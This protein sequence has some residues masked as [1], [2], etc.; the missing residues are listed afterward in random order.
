MLTPVGRAGAEPIWDAKALLKR[1]CS[2]APLPPAR[3]RGEVSRALSFRHPAIQYL[4]FI[5]GDGEIGLLCL[6]AAVTMHKTH[7]DRPGNGGLGP[8]HHPREPLGAPSLVCELC[9]AASR[10]VSSWRPGEVLHSASRVIH[11]LSRRRA[12]RQ[13]FWTTLAKWPEFHGQIVF[14]RR[15]LLSAP[16]RLIEYK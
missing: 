16:Q 12:W 1:L 11:N 4:Q 13:L 15:W 14:L 7:E 5:D 9:S 2:A 10:A 6:P 8:Q 3:A